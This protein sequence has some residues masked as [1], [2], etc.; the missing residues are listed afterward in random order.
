[1]PYISLTL[2]RQRNH[3]KFFSVM[4]S[5]LYL[6]DLCLLRIRISHRALKRASKEA[7]VGTLKERNLKEQPFHISDTI[8]AIPD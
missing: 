7:E 2:K 5:D 4:S 8:S 1:M 6:T 3:T